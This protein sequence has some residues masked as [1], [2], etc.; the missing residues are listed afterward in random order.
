[1]GVLNDKRCNR[2]INFMIEVYNNNNNIKPFDTS[3]H[4]MMLTTIKKIIR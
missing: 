2:I 4:A 1:M 3:T